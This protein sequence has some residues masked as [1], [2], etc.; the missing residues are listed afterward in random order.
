MSS[1][2][3][4]TVNGLDPDEDAELRRLHHLIPYAAPDSQLMKRYDE[5]RARDRRHQ[6]RE[7]TEDEV[8]HV[9]PPRPRPR[10]EG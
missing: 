8:A 2:I 5:L 1:E 4:T 9:M 3:E 7:L 10:S 6:V